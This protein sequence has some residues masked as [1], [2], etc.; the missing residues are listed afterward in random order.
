MLRQIHALPGLLAAL[1]VAMLAVTGAILSLDPALERAGTT[2]PNAA[3]ISVAALAEVVTAKHAEVDR[4]V[5]TAS[6]SVIVYYFDGDR[7]G[8]DLV[9]PTTGLTIGA[10]EP[11][12]FFQ[13]VTNLHRSFLMGDAG[14]AAAGIGALAMVV[15]AISGTM[16]LAA[17][18]GGWTAILRSIRGTTSQRLHTELGRCAVLGLILS[19]LTGCY[20]SLA[21]FGVLPDD[22]IIKPSV[23]T[24]VNGGPRTPVGQ[25]A[26]L[27]AV[28]LTDLR[29]LTFPYAGDLTDVYTLTTAQGVGH[30][31]A[32]TG[33]M[34]AYL[35]HSLTRQVYETIYML[36]TGQGLWPLALILGLTALTV[37]VLSAV[38]ALL[39]W[40]RRSALPRIRQNVRAQ[41]ADTIILVG[42][43]GNSTWGLAI[44][45]HD[46]L[47]KAG[48]RVHTAPMNRL[49]PTY[50]QAARMLIL[51][52]TY[53]D[54]AAPVSAHDFFARMDAVKKPLPVAVLGFGDRTFPRFCKFAEDVADA[55]RAKG[56]PVLVKLKLID[57]QSAQEFAQWGADLGGAI[58]TELMLTHIA[59]RPKTVVLELIERVDYGAKIGACTAILRFAAP[60]APPNAGLWHRLRAPRLPGFEVGDLVGILPPESDLPRLYSLASANSDGVLEICV[61]KRPGGL[62]SGFLHQLEPGGTI[63][64]F[65]RRN[66]AFRP[67]RGKAPLILIGAGSGIGPLAGFI[68]HNTGRRRVHLYWG[69][70][71]PASDFLYEGEMAK[72]LADQRLTRLNTV[73]SRIPGGGYVKDR[74]ASDAIELRGLIQRGAQVLVCGGRDMA[75][76]V[77]R[78]LE[79][80]TGPMGLDLQTLKSGGRYIEDVY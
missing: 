15:L 33:Q 72:Y 55:L 63:E 29:E 16:M 71:D 23:S 17:R 37:P 1:L 52:A 9:D 66:P 2:L 54:G 10:H 70:R 34:L 59:T 3:Q 50:A 65:I 67:A 42:S 22:T 38:G 35:P 58:G 12:A 36:H 18:L 74:I 21:T 31:D 27:K 8:A 68:R 77:A 11:S 79:A 6:G 39:W 61:R 76:G 7:A 80:I 64:A 51:T 25:L 20:M 28:D 5:K 47:T 30:V 46:A 41:S 75:A 13:F 49:A 14:R 26:A 19:A 4:I 48:H 73:F 62:C 45:L 57:R 44:T 69:G 78:A 43:E 24:E 56:W 60:K 53:G 40:K 32:A